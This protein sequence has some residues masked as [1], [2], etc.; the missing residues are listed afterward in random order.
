MF[1]VGLLFLPLSHMLMRSFL[2]QAPAQKPDSS[3][4]DKSSGSFNSEM[5]ITPTNP[6][7]RQKFFEESHHKRKRMERDN[8]SL[9]SLVTSQQSS[10]RDL[11]VSLLL[12]AESRKV[13]AES[14]RTLTQTNQRQHGLIEVLNAKADRLHQ[15]VLVLAEENANAQKKHF[16]AL[17]TL[18]DKKHQAEM[19]AEKLKSARALLESENQRLH[20]DLAQAMEEN[21]DLRQK[22]EDNAI[23]Q[24][25]L[26]A[27]RVEAVRA[28]FLPVLTHGASGPTNATVETVGESETSSVPPKG[29]KKGT[30][31]KKRKHAQAQ[32]GPHRR[33]ARDKKPPTRYF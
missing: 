8:K 27:A 22:M 28:D 26:E 9:R 6:T 21:A 24:K 15:Q 4:S 11:S 3:K 30:V 5:S 33:S 14:F 20:G 31:T 7:E 29:K 25:E 18:K 19:A 23:A 17:A 16:E 2:C 13:N 12:E 10:I 1:L 32:V